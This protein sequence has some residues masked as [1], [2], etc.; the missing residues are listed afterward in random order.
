MAW[1]LWLRGLLAAIISGA[2]NSLAVWTID[3]ADFNFDTGLVK[4]LKVAAVSSLLGAALYLKQHPD[5]WDERI[6]GR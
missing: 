2:C 6:A 5:P 4:L 3:P 1:K